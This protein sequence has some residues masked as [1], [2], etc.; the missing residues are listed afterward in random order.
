MSTKRCMG[1][2]ER[3][4]GG[5]MTPRVHPHI[6]RLVLMNG[7]TASSSSLDEF[8]QI[9][10]SFSLII[11]TFLENLDG[12]SA[13]RR[14]PQKDSSGILASNSYGLTLYNACQSQIML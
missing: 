11:P 2:S 4:G 7:R 6:S 10:L 8:H 13:R 14:K 12:T 1:K 5:Y 3:N 9:R